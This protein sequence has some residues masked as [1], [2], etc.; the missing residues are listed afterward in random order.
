MNE[1]LHFN[2]KK[3]YSSPETSTINVEMEQGIAAGSASLRPNMTVKTDWENQETQD[4]DVFIPY[5]Q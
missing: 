1:E 2:E 5:N 4:S 3:I